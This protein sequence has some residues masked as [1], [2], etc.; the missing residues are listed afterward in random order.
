M[1]IVIQVTTPLHRCA[2]GRSTDQQF[3]G[4]KTLPNQCHFSAVDT[5]SIYD[6]HQRVEGTTL[7][8]TVDE[9]R[10]SIGDHLKNR[11]RVFA[12]G[13][14]RGC[15]IGIQQ[16]DVRIAGIIRVDRIQ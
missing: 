1:T 3:I 7:T 5:I 16:I 8:A 9:Y 15:V 12:R 11:L 4:I 13:V 2:G 6:G 14:M 10:I